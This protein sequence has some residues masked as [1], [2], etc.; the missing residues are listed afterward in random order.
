MNRLFLIFP[1]A[2]VTP[3][4]PKIS[5]ISFTE[6]L[7]ESNANFLDEIIIKIKSQTIEINSKLDEEIIEIAKT[8]SGDCLIFPHRTLHQ[9]SK[10]IG[11]KVIIR[12][13]IMYRIKK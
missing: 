3:S 10:T 7:F 9:G 6:N 5:R 11:R 13:D 2:N 1:N 8:E 12:T 4:A